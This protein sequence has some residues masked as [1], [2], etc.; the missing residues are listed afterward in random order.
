VTTPTELLEGFGNELRVGPWTATESAL[1]DD[2]F[3]PPTL[4]A[5]ANQAAGETGGTG[6]AAAALAAAEEEQPRLTIFTTL[7]RDAARDD[8]P[9]GSLSG[10]PFAVKDLFDVEGVVTLAGSK[11]KAADAPATADATAVARLRGAGAV[12]V[13]AT[14][15]DEFAY[16][17]TTENSHY[18]TTRNPHDPERLAGGSS[19]GSAAAVAAGIVPLALGTDTNGSVRVPASFCGVYGLRP[20]S[21]RVPLSGAT[22]F[23]ASFDAVGILARSVGDVALTLDVIAGPDG[24]DPCCRLTSESPFTSF[25]GAERPLRAVRSAGELWAGA[26]P[27]VLDAVERVAAAL[28]ARGA[29]ELPEVGRARAAASVMTAAEGAER[30]QQLLR[31]NPEIVDPRV[32]GRFLAGL[33]VPATDYLAAQR[34][35]RWWR[36]QVLGLLAEVDVL[37]LPTTACTAPRLDEPLI[38]IDGITLPVGAV[39]GRFTQPLSFIGLPAL[40]VPVRRSG[41]LPIGVQLASRPGEEGLLLAAAAL[42]EAAGVVSP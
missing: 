8:P 34:F 9:A 4:C 29:L 21:G 30:H 33:D 26:Q 25:L 23:A 16:G 18:G 37:V 38:E 24:I 41:G 35:R 28:G 7:L 6:A 39:L 3:T 14:N 42:L 13:G 5:A 11:A 19:G 12:L 15:M 17:F 31:R 1:L 40:S 27:H 20:T 32:R 36:R 10:V 22:L 2:D